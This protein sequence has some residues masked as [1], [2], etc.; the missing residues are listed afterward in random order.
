MTQKRLTRFGLPFPARP[1]SDETTFVWEPT[2]GI[3]LD[4]PISDLEP[5][6][7]PSAQNYIV[8]NGALTPRNYLTPRSTQSVQPRI[9]ILGGMEVVD[10]LGQT[11]PF[12]SHATQPLWYSVGSWSLLSYTSAFGVNDPPANSGNSL[13]DMTQ[14]YSDRNDENVVVFASPSYQSLY[15]WQ[16]NTTV[17][18]S[19]TGAPRARA[20]AVFNNYLM[21]WNI[22]QGNSDFVQR[23][24]WSDRG[25]LS[26]WTGSNSLA[27]FLDILDAKGQGTKLIPQEDRLLAFTDKEVWQVFNVGLPSIFDYRAV[28]RTVGCPWPGTIVDTPNGVLFLAQDYNVY[29]IPRG[30]GNAVKVGQAIQQELQDNIDF[31]R[32]AWALYDR[33]NNQY[34]LYYPTRGGT[35]YAQSALYLDLDGAAWMPQT[36]TQ[37]VSYGWQGSLG[38]SSKGTTWADLTAAGLTWNDLSQTWAQL[39]GSG[40]F[41]PLS[42]YA[43]SS[44]GTMYY[45]SSGATRD[46]GQPVTLRWRSHGL[47]GGDPR[48]LKTLREVRLDYQADSTSDV[49]VRISMDG[50]QTFDVGQRVQVPPASVESQAVFYVFGAGRYPMFEV[51]QDSGKMRIYRCHATFRKQGR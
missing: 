22:R 31:P 47:G 37:S 29:A 51:V 26:S 42:V 38:T 1:Q 35:G 45:M 18:S 12:A 8:L 17:F 15:V 24:Q 23:L 30:G 11:Y 10:V 48:Q 9:P 6:F 33:E 27:G 5:G 14:M 41:G 39:A 36:F 34:Q 4:Q 44:D 50:G 32:R 13:W 19:L 3:K 43:G 21:A 49:T 16:S 40:G 46:D 20:V 28:D 7:T 25:S 2:L